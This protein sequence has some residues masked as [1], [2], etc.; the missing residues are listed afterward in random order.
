MPSC[1]RVAATLPAML[2]TSLPNR[3]AKFS[4]TLERERERA[5]SRRNLR[6]KPCITKQACEAA[7][8]ARKNSGPPAAFLVHPSFVL[9]EIRLTLNLAGAEEALKREMK[10]DSSATLDF[11]LGGIQFQQDKVP[12]A[13]ANH[14]RA[15]AKFPAFRRAWRNLGL[16]HVRAGRHDDAIRALTRM[17]ELGGGDGYAYGLLAYAY[18]AISGSHINPA[19]TLGLL[20]AGRIDARRAVSYVVFQIGGGNEYL[21]LPAPA[22]GPAFADGCAVVWQGDDLVEAKTI[23]PIAPAA[24][25][26]TAGANKGWT[27]LKSLPRPPADA[28]SSPDHR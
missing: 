23:P 18:G 22:S 27:V 7:S 6:R 15:V 1:R 14:Q 26:V 25:M 9:L 11:T 19:V 21:I 20:A 5:V 4:S 2:S 8:P 24:L 17:I 10:A 3:T 28:A 12:E 16:I 13:L